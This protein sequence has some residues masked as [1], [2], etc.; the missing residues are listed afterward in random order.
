MA[1]FSI[2]NGSWSIDRFVKSLSS[3]QAAPGGGAAAA[4]SGALGAS[5]GSMVG[6]II[7]SRKKLPVRTRNKA[8]RAVKELD[9]L[10]REFKRLMEKDSRAYAD[11]SLKVQ[12][13]KKGRL[14][15]DRL[16]GVKKQAI[17]VPLAICEASVKGLKEIG[18]LNQLS[19]TQLRADLLAGS[20]LLRGAF[21][22]ASEMVRAN[23]KG[24]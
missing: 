7:L 10:S 16:A 2:P 6:R 11:F 14:S 5:L 4:L 1:K 17:E 22:A 23:L 18:S 8:R 19:G 13:V 20:S 15:E 12:E 24:A 3:N 21:Y 9:G